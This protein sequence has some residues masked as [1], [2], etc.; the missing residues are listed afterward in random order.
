MWRLHSGDGMTNTTDA[1]RSAARQASPW[2]ERT[3]RIGFV[4]RGVVY[5]IIGGLAARAALG[6]GGG[7]TTDPRGA[8]QVLAGQPF[9]TVLLWLAALGLAGYAIWKLIEATSNPRGDSGGRRAL[10]AISGVVHFALAASAARLAMGSGS[11]SSEGPGVLT[12]FVDHPIGRWVA[13]AGG[14]AFALYGLSQ[15]AKA[16]RSEIGRDF[17]LSGVSE[18]AREA[19][20][21]IARFGIAAR[22]VVFTILG[23]LFALAAWRRGTAE[24]QDT[25]DALDVLGGLPGGQI[26]L[27]VVAL[28]LIAYGIYSILN[29]RYRRIDA[30]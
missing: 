22:G 10:H 9:G 17:Q 8:L 23:L 3:A 20:V 12:R 15:I 21:Q 11:G 1:A 14:L 27:A 30:T 13:I 18:S 28:G 24:A 29:A 25:G 16:I 26:I 19:V 5:I 2:I 7:E 4:A 6:S